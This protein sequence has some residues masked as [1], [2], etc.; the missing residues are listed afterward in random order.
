MGRA[1]YCIKCGAKLLPN[2][3]FCMNCGTP[4]YKVPQEPNVE[5]KPEIK[6]EPKMEVQPEP[7]LEVKAESR[8]AYTPTPMN[9]PAKNPYSNGNPAGVVA[10]KPAPMSAPN[11]PVIEPI[12]KVKNKKKKKKIIILSVLLTILVV[13][14][15][16]GAYVAI[17]LLATPIPT[18]GRAYKKLLVSGKTYAA[19]ITVTTDG[20]K[21]KAEADVKF[22]LKNR[23]IAIDDVYSDDEPEAEARGYIDTKNKEMCFYE[24]DNSQKMYVCNNYLTYVYKDG[25]VKHE[26]ILN[27][28]NFDK[29]MDIIATSMALVSGED[30]KTEEIVGKILDIYPQP[31]NKY[32]LNEVDLSGFKSKSLDR[33]KWNAIKYFTDT[34]WLEENF[35]YEKERKNGETVYSFEIS[36]KSIKAIKE[37]F[38]DDLV[39]LEIDFYNYSMDQ[40]GKEIPEE[41][42]E[43][44]FKEAVAFEFKMLESVMKENDTELELSFGVKKGVISSI[45]ISTEDFELKVSLEETDDISMS[46]S[47]FDKYYNEAKKAT[48]G[49]HDSI[50]A[51]L[52]SKCSSNTY[53]ISNAIEEYYYMNHKL[54]SNTDD[55]LKALQGNELPVCPWNSAAY[56]VTLNPNTSSYEVKCN[57]PECQNDNPVTG[58]FKTPTEIC[59]DNERMIGDAIRQYYVKYNKL[60]ENT[61]DLLEFMNTDTFPKCPVNSQSYS[62]SV[63]PNYDSYTVT[64][65]DSHCGNANYSH[66]GYYK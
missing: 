42:D 16:L 36:T 24:S 50:E 52:D 1:E 21:D 45:E 17:R 51:E 4:V 2:A 29:V 58:S 32:P 26:L 56:V 9:Y 41:Y 43:K 5:L 39:E 7:K 12:K 35:G 11:G 13:I 54:P 23:Y 10:P 61:N 38:E 60:P 57:D 33:I 34:K 65:K 48:A 59:Q 25:E 37:I 47:D 53:Q 66:R 46:K 55:I 62:I 19:T 31:D 6:P 30:V 15:G 44:K 28:D 27:D 20:D 3:T 63:D 22:D 14:I 64:C 40:M 8:P 49:Q 18:L